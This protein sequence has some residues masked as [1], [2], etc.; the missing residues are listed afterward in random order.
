MGHLVN[1]DRSYRLLQQQLDTTVTGAPDSP[2]LQQILRLLFPA[3]DAEL[4]TRL[5]NRLTPVDALARKLG[6]A[7]DELAGRLTDMARRG[8]VIDLEHDGRRWVALAPVVIGFFEF[9]FM[10]A[11]D[12]LPLAE[13]AR[14]FDEYMH[15]GPFSRAVF[16]GQTQI[17][18]SLVREE[19]LPVGDHTEMLDWERASHVVRSASAIGVSLC[20]CRHK[21][22]HLGRACD[23]PQRCCLSLQLR[24]RFAHPQRHCRADHGGRGDGDPRRVQ[25]AGL[26][27][28]GDNVQ[29]Q[30]AYIC[31][32]CGCC[33]GMVEAI[34]TFDLRRRSSRRTGSWRSTRRSAGRAASV[35][36]PVRSRRSRLQEG[37][38]TGEGGPTAERAVCDES[39]CL[40]CGVCHGACKFGAIAMRPRA[41]RV[42][43]P[44]TVFDRVAM[45]AIERGK[46]AD[47]IFERPDGLGHRALARLVKVIEWSPLFKAAMAIRPLRSAFLGR[48]V[49]EGRKGGI[50]DVVGDGGPEG[51]TPRGRRAGGR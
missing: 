3:A 25:R 23:R 19:A 48:I 15:D 45:M 27:Q 28:T 7:E 36:P 4:A 22:E 24:R 6:M 31:N 49:A 42:F 37:Q 29:R 1:P 30:V 2:A 10:R 26:A 44:E 13:L 41:Q 38:R 17:G 39:V 50:G 18:R 46:L 12:E 14:L 35:R 8:L 34:R 20:A 11:R 40:G 5:P 16:A 51:G 21:A 47:L 32:C 33:C 43:T 9:T